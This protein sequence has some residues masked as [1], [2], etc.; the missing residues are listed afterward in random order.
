MQPLATDHMRDRLE[1][2][3]SPLAR[4]CRFGGVAGGWNFV[5]RNGLQTATQGGRLAPD[6]FIP[7]FYVLDSDNAD[8]YANKN[9]VP[10]ALSDV[11]PSRRVAIILHGI[12]GT[13]RNW[14]PFTRK[15][16]SHFPD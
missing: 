8:M 3:N 4:I 15:L 5:R 1:F 7:K 10:S 14:V 2:R 16:L 12:L 13:G 6:S 11:D 9:P